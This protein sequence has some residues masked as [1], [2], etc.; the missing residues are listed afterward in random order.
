[1]EVATI[2]QKEVIT[3]RCK[4]KKQQCRKRHNNQKIKENT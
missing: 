3:M 1:M 2:V 4:G